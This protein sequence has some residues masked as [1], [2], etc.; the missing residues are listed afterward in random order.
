[1]SRHYVDTVAARF[2]GVADEVAASLQ[3]PVDRTPTWS[4]WRS[5][6][7]IAAGHGITDLNLVKPGVGE[8]TRVLLRRVPWQ[9]LV[10]PDRTADLTHVL[11]LARARQVPVVEVPG[12][13]YSC[14]GLIRQVV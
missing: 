2:A 6:E 14:V 9:V 7:T 12:L 5:I 8:T 1:M 4:G 3:E 11:L 13:P 10:H